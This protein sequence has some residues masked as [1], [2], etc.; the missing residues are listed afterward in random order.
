[1]G[2]RELSETHCINITQTFIIY[3]RQYPY[4][5]ADCRELSETHCINITQTFIIYE[6]LIV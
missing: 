3:E 2:R 4:L 5:Y 1:M 6:R